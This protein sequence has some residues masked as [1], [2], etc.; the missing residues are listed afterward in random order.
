VE[1]VVV[2]ASKN[3]HKKRHWRL[4]TEEAA[5]WAAFAM[6]RSVPRDAGINP[7]TLKISGLYKRPLQVW[8]YLR[9][10]PS[11]CSPN[12]SLLRQACLNSPHTSLRADPW[13]VSRHLAAISF[14]PLP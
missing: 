9:Q 11:P 13:Q 2:P 10:F 8:R 7:T 4:E 3:L 5:N 14:T 6:T 12:W 1:G